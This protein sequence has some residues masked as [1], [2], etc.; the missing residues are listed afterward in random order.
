[1]CLQVGEP[2]FDVLGFHHRLVRSQGRRGTGKDI[3]FPRWLTSKAMHHAGDRIREV[4]ARRRLLIWS[5]RTLS[6]PRLGLGAPLKVTYNVTSLQASR[7]VDQPL[8]TATARFRLQ[9]GSASRPGLDRCVRT[10]H[11]GQSAN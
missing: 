11:L 8:H 2:E 4:T 10:R 9:S 6:G 5:C 1:V 7:A 3:V